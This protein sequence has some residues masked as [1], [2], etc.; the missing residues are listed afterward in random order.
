MK[1]R[2][3]GA[4]VEV[5]MKDMN[6]DDRKKMNIQLFRKMQTRICAAHKTTRRG[7][8]LCNY[9]RKG[10]KSQQSHRHAGRQHEGCLSSSDDSTGVKQ[11]SATAL[12]TRSSSWRFHCS[13]QSAGRDAN[14][15]WWAT[16]V[17]VIFLPTV[18]SGSCQTSSVAPSQ[19]FASTSNDRTE[20]NNATVKPVKINRD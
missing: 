14:R 1:T 4:D 7:P 19:T 16:P 12:P 5:K 3:G 8:S 6:E 2:L 17:D 11:T 9:F 10:I 18:T 15:C 13:V 20:R